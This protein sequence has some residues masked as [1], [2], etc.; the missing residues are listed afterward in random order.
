MDRQAIEAVWQLVKRLPGKAD[1]SR[2]L[3][4]DQQLTAKLRST[5]V[6]LFPSS[7]ETKTHQ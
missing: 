6:E 5:D 4:R 7:R 3:F 1:A 2:E